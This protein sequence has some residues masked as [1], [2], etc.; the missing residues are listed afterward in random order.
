MH[1]LAA[2]PLTPEVITTGLSLLTALFQYLDKR[3][4]KRALETVVDGVEEAAA[5][6]TNTKRAVAMQAASA[7]T[8]AL[9]DATLR[10]RGYK[11]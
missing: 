8:H 9:I 5:K 4:H 10:R 2:I 3:D 6:E 11:K 1:T 7:T